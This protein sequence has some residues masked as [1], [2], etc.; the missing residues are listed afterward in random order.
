VKLGSAFL[1]YVV[2]V[3]EA[4]V[5]YF[6][7][8]HNRPLGKEVLI[9][10]VNLAHVNKCCE[11]SISRHFALSAVLA[12]ANTCLILNILLNL[13]QLALDARV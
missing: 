3:L 2:K 13:Q 9:N 6:C 5:F 12:A 8:L 7:L 10:L 11:L 4:S 1:V